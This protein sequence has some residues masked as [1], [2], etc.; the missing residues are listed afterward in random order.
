MEF[1]FKS[2]CL[3]FSKALGF[4][5]TNLRKILKSNKPC[6]YLDKEKSPFHM[7]RLMYL[8]SKSGNQSKYFA[9]FSDPEKQLVLACSEDPSLEEYMIPIPN[10]NF[11]QAEIHRYFVDFSDSADSVQNT[12]ENCYDLSISFD[13][14]GLYESF[15]F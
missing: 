1:Y 7:A 9:L 13:A 5:L 14:R 3:E 15:N 4:N 8:R 12:H 6:K 11:Q 10:G 2:L